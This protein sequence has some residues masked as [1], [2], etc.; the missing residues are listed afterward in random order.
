MGAPIGA[1]FSLFSDF[2]HQRHRQAEATVEGPLGMLQ[3]EAADDV[4][5]LVIFLGRKSEVFAQLGK[6]FQDG[7]LVSRY[8]LPAAVG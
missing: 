4:K 2:L 7:F 5:H 8:A 1:P 6:L 3:T